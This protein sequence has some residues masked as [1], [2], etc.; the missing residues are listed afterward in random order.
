[1]FLPLVCPQGSNRREYEVTICFRT[2]NLEL[3]FQIIGGTSL[4]CSVIVSLCVLFL[5]N[6]FDLNHLFLSCVLGF[7]ATF[8]ALGLSVTVYIIGKFLLVLQELFFCWETTTTFAALVGVDVVSHYRALGVHCNAM[9]AKAR[10]TG[11]QG[12]AVPAGTPSFYALMSS[13]FVQLSKGKEVFSAVQTVEG[14]LLSA[15]GGLVL[16]ELIRGGK[17]LVTLI[18]SEDCISLLQLLFVLF[19][20]TLPHVSLLGFGV[21]EGD[22]ALKTLQTLMLI[23]LQRGDPGLSLDLSCGGSPLTPDNDLLYLHHVHT[24]TF[25]HHSAAWSSVWHL[26]TLRLHICEKS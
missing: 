11:E 24:D 21:T 15:V 13:V 26:C 16:A 2:R 22:E 6:L 1:M 12:A 19:P 8:F 10:G 25:R 23:G 3:L 14:L 18:A 20:M 17:T 4:C 9:V 5:F 7:T